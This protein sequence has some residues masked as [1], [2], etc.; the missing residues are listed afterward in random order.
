MTD[1][2]TMLN[3]S[4]DTLGDQVSLTTSK[5]R[6]VRYFFV[7]MACLFP[8][9][10][11]LGFMPSYQ[12]VSD[13]SFKPHWFVHV[14][15]ALMAGWLFIFLTQTFLAARGNL[16]FHRQ[17]GM[18]FAFYGAMICLLMPTTSIRARIAF[19]PPVED[20]V[21]S[22]L[23]VELMAFAMFSL[24]FIWGILVRKNAPAHKRLLLLATI[25]LMGASIDR[26]S[27]LPRLENGLFSN[28][29]YLD[30]LLIPLFIYDFV[31]VGRIHKITLLGSAC[32]VAAQLL[33]GTVWESQAWRTFWFNRFAPFVEQAVEI[34]LSDA[35]IDPLLGDYGD[36]NWHMTLG[37]EE[38]K[39]YLKLPDIPRLEA[40][41][42]S[43]N[44]LFLRTTTWNLF[45]ERDAHGQVTKVI[46]KQ[47]A[48]T[49][50]AARIR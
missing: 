41:A 28:F 25:I 33:V 37:R 47:G 43:E 48:R 42:V 32:L 46:N 49:W 10:T 39:L 19:P 7:G 40:G 22:V 16:K 6:Y 18:F 35:Q 26:M 9:L 14:H 5:S 29:A 38:D 2:T 50:E 17:L 44:E 21:W 31:S 4:S 13:G 45:F 8:V 24:F 1:K 36:K 23:A 27:W 11:V 3:I 12:A 20:F 34:K 30:A 15:G